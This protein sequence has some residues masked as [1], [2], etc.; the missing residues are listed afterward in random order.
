MKFI[1]LIRLG[2]VALMAANLGACIVVGPP[3][4]PMA[5]VIY[6]TPPPVAVTPVAPQPYYAAPAVGYVWLF[7]PTYGWGW[8]HPHHGWHRGWR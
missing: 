5:P 2:T 6:E 3:H 7:N 8:R 4:P 1:P